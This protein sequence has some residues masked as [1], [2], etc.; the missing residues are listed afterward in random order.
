[1]YFSIKE[2]KQWSAGPILPGGAVVTGRRRCTVLGG[3]GLL[4]HFGKI[5]FLFCMWLCW[6]EL[7]SVPAHKGNKG[8]FPY[9]GCR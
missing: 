7:P 2:N 5:V 9:Y 1:M 3:Q 6:Q 4:P 8:K